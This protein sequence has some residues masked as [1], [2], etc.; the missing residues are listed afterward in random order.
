MVAP[1]RYYALSCC[2]RVGFIIEQ[3]NLPD[4]AI[5]LRRSRA[6]VRG[7]GIR[8]FAIEAVAGTLTIGAIAVAPFAA[9]FLLWILKHLAMGLYRL[10]REKPITVIDPPRIDF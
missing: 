4:G 6:L 5:A 7:N 9:A 1:W 3:R 2:R 8:V 10:I